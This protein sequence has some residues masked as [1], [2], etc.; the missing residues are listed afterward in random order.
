[1]G[2]AGLTENILDLANG[3]VHATGTGIDAAV[4]SACQAKLEVTAGDL[5]AKRAGDVAGVT[6]EIQAHIYAG[7]AA[8]IGHKQAGADLVGN[9]AAGGAAGGAKVEGRVCRHIKDQ[10]ELTAVDGGV[11][12]LQRAACAAGEQVRIVLAGGILGGDLKNTAVDGGVDVALQVHIGGNRGEM[13]AVD[14]TAVDGQIH[15]ALVGAAV[16]A[17]TAVMGADILLHGAAVDGNG[18]VAHGQH[19]MAVIDSAHLGAV[20]NDQA[21]VAIGDFVVVLGI[22]D[23]N[24]VIFHRSDQT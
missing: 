14:R 13:G 23:P 12:I 7:G 8:G 4:G 19:T 1:M 20:F 21:I 3:Q 6:A 10:I 18:A 5:V 11:Y 9:I 2:A 16:V 17:A 22:G 15:I 24:V